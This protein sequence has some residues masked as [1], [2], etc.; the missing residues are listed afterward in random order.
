MLHQT[1][2]MCMDFWC[3]I[4][5]EVLSI[6]WC[7]KFD[8]QNYGCSYIFYNVTYKLMIIC[9]CCY[10]LQNI[11]LTFS[12][13]K[14]KKNNLSIHHKSKKGLKYYYWWVSLWKMGWKRDG[15]TI[16]A[17][18]TMMENNW[19]KKSIKIQPLLLLTLFI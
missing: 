3:I 12:V 6:F 9:C 4:K 10:V 14:K 13:E 16:H 5:T 8:T 11:N 1:W 19:G 17:F 7:W 18:K 2:T 15:K